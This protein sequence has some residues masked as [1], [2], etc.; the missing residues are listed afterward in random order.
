VRAQMPVGVVAIWALIGVVAAV[1]LVRLHDGDFGMGAGAGL[2]VIG[3]FALGVLCAS[4]RAEPTLYKHVDE[5]VAE[6]Q[7]L[8]VCRRHLKV[9]GR[10]VPG[11]IERRL[12]TDQYRF[13]MESRDDRPPATLEVRYDGLVP[14]T[15]QWGAEIIAT[16]TIFGGGGLDV[17][18]D[19]IQAKCPTRIWPL[20]EPEWRSVGSWP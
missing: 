13:R 20:P 7:K 8:H 17:D 16:G 2:F 19:G 1:I 4:A 12:G 9:H 14:D 11:S 3:G 15:F 18:P 10:V 6:N 5:V